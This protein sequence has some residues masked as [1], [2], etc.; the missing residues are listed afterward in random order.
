MPLTEGA[1]E[2][3]NK[4]WQHIEETSDSKAIFFHWQKLDV[5]AIDS[6]SKLM[7]LDLIFQGYERALEDYEKADLSDKVRY[8]IP[9]IGQLVFLYKKVMDIPE[10]DP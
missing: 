8:L 6:P 3:V 5:T 2:M 10:V 7:L 4:M 9:K 1:K